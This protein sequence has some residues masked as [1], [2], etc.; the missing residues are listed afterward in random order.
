MRLEIFRTL[1]ISEMPE[2]DETR[3]YIG[4]KE[5]Q[6]TYDQR[7]ESIKKLTALNKD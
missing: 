4:R 5:L 7:I 2:M 6:A 3:A 1:R